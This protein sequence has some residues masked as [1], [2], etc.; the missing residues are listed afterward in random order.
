MSRGRDCSAASDKDTRVAR[1]P[2]KLGEGTLTSLRGPMACDTVA[3]RG[4]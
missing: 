2:L 4:A 1:Y 3:D